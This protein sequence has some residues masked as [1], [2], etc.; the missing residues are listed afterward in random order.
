G[1]NHRAGFALHADHLWRYLDAGRADAV[2]AVDHHPVPFGQALGD[3]LQLVDP[4]AGFHDAPFDPVVLAEY[5]EVASVLIGQHGFL[6][7]QQ[8]RRIAGYRHLHPGKLTGAQAPVRIGH[9]GAV[10]QGAGAGVV[11][12]VDEVQFTL[13]GKV[14]L[15]RQADAYRPRF[16]IG[17]VLGGLL[18]ALEVHVQRVNRDQ[19]GEQGGIGGGEVAEGGLGAADA[20]THRRPDLGVFQIQLGAAHAGFSG[21]HRGFGHGVGSAALFILLAGN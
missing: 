4:A 17:V 1:D 15:T 20:A 16:A 2:Q 10:L 5:V 7:H 12:V 9:A 6:V 3:D 11:L 18:V 14:I 13:I 21:V 19:S 8:R